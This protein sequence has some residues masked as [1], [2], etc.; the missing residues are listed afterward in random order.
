MA[1]DEVAPRP[2]MSV[3]RTPRA[4]RINSHALP[5]LMVMMLV[6]PNPAASAMWTLPQAQGPLAFAGES[7]VSTTWSVVRFLRNA[8][9]SLAAWSVARA[10]GANCRF[11]E[12]LMIACA[13][14]DPALFRRGGT[15]YGNVWLFDEGFD[16]RR[17]RSE[18]RHADQWAVMG[19]GLGPAYVL[20]EVRWPEAANPFE[21]SAGLADGCYQYRPGC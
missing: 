20:A 5:L 6:I 8:P 2:P 18:T 21:R 16:Q 12:E 15:T 1:L 19:L 13:K 14:T 11:V 7:A 9:I 4:A 10:T 3:D 17:L